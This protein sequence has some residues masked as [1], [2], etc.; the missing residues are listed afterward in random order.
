MNILIT[1]GAGF[2]GS[3]LSEALVGQGHNV[4]VW[5]NLLTG[6]MDNLD[7]VMSK[8]NFRFLK[9]DIRDGHSILPAM[10][11][12]DVAYD[13]FSDF[14]PDVII[15]AAASYADP[16]DWV[17]DTET[18]C[19]G[20]AFIAKLAKNWGVKRLI[21]FQT[22]LCY[23]LHPIDSPLTTE[24]NVCPSGSTYAITK[25]T[26]E[27]IIQMSGVPHISFR[28][29][30]VCGPRNLSGPVPTFYLRVS[31]GKQCFVVDTRRDFIFVQDLVSLV[32]R[33]VQGEGRDNNVYHISTGSD[34]SIETMYNAVYKAMGRPNVPEL[35]RRV[36]GEDDVKTLLI[37][38]SKTQSDFDGWGAFTD[39]ESG[40]ASAVKWYRE[41]NFTQTFT[42]LKDMD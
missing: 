26:G 23:G 33:A 37:D 30:N 24:S 14:T 1:G 4:M 16:S 12:P 11:S 2:I 40:V 19:T 36:A 17:R 39:L 41:N 15:H 32:V 20:T 18:N 7:S 27:Q 28:L 42:H 22:S 25:T 29:A 31:Q 6:R 35:E 8:P 10:A 5:D 3:H 9:L 34:Y 38:P 21:Y 13:M